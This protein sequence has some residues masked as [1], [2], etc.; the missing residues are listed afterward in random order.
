MQPPPQAPSPPQAPC[1]FFRLSL[2]NPSRRYLDVVVNIFGAN[3]YLG[4]LDGLTDFYDESVRTHAS[5]HARMRTCVPSSPRV[6]A[7]RSCPCR[8]GGS[9]ITLV[10]RLPKLSPVSLH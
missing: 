4:E 7:L 10:H 2:F 9:H 6:L 3:I 1:V 5:S 8:V